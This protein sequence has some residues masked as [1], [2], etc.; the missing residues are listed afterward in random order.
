MTVSF[1]EHDIAYCVNM[2]VCI[3]PS[4]YKIDY[5]LTP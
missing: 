5:N 2:I 3:G 4:I 1:A